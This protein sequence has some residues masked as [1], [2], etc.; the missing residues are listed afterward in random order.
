MRASSFSKLAVLALL[1]IAIAGCQT[2]PGKGASILPTGELPKASARDWPNAKYDELNQRA[3]GYGLARIP[4]LKAY[5]DG[6]LVKIKKQSGVPDWPGEVFILAT[7]SLE[8][9]ATAAGNIYISPSWVSAAESEDELV[10]LLGHEFGHVYLH[11]HQLEG[12]IQDAD[13]MAQLAAIGFALA[14]K[15]GQVAGWSSLDSLLLGYVATR[16]LGSAAW[17][18]DQESAADTFGLNVS[19]GL[20]YSYDYGMKV[21]LERLASWESVNEERQQAEKAQLLEMVKQQARD[22]ALGQ[23]GNNNVLAQPLAELN[24]GMTG[25]LHQGSESLKGGW[26]AATTKHPQILARIDAIA[27]AVEPLPA[28]VISHAPI[29]DPL[30]R[31]VRVKD[32]GAALRNYRLAAEAIETKDAAKAF[33]LA[34]EAASGPTATHALPLMA[35]YRVRSLSGLP[36]QKKGKLVTPADLLDRNI[37]SVP[38]RA[39][40]TYVERATQL[41]A[42]GEREAGLKVMRDGLS[43][44]QEAGNAWPQAI[45]FTG[46]ARGWNDAKQLAQVCGTKFKSLAE[47]CSLAA[48]SPAEL[49]ERERK[50][51]EKGE[52]LA[53]KLIKKK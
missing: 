6:L 9:Y 43:Y 47:T 26:G 33:Q 3:K 15:T 14:K 30:T 38:D 20:G 52:Q 22:S 32:T 29:V 49:A 8:A 17:G 13:Q 31:A 53:N 34:N 23:S 50:S 2:V 18:R 5:L 12:A 24:A 28:S 1:P 51:K 36:S 25:L 10:A 37:A 16:D 40:L 39:W 46:Q 35:L 21:F 7:S 48:A 4:G 45:R 11:Y 41:Y 42:H 27:L 44:F 19:L